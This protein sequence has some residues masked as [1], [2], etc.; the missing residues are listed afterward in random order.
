MTTVAESS[1]TQTDVLARYA[2]SLSVDGLSRPVVEQTRRILYDT[3]GVLLGSSATAVVQKLAAAALQRGGSPEATVIGLS[4]KLPFEQASFI[5]GVGGHQIELDDSHGP[6][7]THP[8]AVMVPAALAAAEFAPAASGADLL[9]GIVV[10][11]DVSARVA[12]GCGVQSIV[13]RGFHN[14]SVCGTVGAAATAG[15]ILGLDAQQMA[16]CLGL[17]ASQAAGLLTWED[18]PSH[19][20]KSFQTGMSARNGLNS[21][22]L[23]ATGYAGAMDALGG[24]YNLLRAFGGATADPSRLTEELGDRFEVLYTDFKRYAS[25]R[26]THAPVDGLLEIMREQ[27][28]RPEDITSIDAE[29]PHS[30]VP[31]VDA[32]PL[33]THNRQYVLALAAY[34][35]AVDYDHFHE[36][37]ISEPRIAELA[38]RVTLRGNDEL[39][40]AFPAA[41]GAHLVVHTRRGDFARQVPLPVGHRDRPISEEQLDQK[42]DRLCGPVL[43]SAATSTLRG[44]LREVE[45]LPSAAELLGPLRA[46]V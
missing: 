5:N 34:E 36:P 27:G 8:A 13:D 42:F 3:V 2:C 45:K 46:G 32:N 1:P 30:S 38:S 28:L 21:A 26:H 12:R 4:L 44:L 40:A 35:K 20:A 31:V 25:C 11:Y 22:M 9:A 18:D 7:L 19:V 10:G 14:T 33:W 6:S 37:W 29:L 23:A 15:R 16:A 41:K 24:R 39:E 17:A 43:S